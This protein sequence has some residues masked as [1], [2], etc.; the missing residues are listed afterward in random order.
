M[1]LESLAILKRMRNDW[2]C[3]IVGD[4]AMRGQLEEQAIRTGLQHEVLFLG[5]HDNVPGL[6]SQS[7]IFVH[8]CI[9]DNQPYSV[10][11]AQMAGLPSVVSTAG[12]CPKW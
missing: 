6:L 2:V 9:Q 3:W 11:E 1:L 12:D 7:D 4:G 10:M 8:T 5:Q